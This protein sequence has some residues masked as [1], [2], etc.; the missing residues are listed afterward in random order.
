[1]RK[2]VHWGKK[3]RQTGDTLKD[4]LCWTDNDN[5][6]AMRATGIICTGA[7]TTR[8]IILNRCI[9]KCI[10]FFIK[11]NDV[12]FK[13]IKSQKIGSGRK[14]KKNIHLL[15]STL[16]HSHSPVPSKNIHE[17]G[18]AGPRRPHN[19]D[20]LSAAKLPWQT[21]QERLATWTNQIHISLGHCAHPVFIVL[22]R[23][24]PNIL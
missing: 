18:L 7:R 23:G 3:E 12:L 5:Y 9:I 19:P 15:S 11:M 20:E 24:I 10:T 16:S 17:S 1:M 21:F 6:A 22:Q 13:R 8:T 4:Q 2:F 14:K